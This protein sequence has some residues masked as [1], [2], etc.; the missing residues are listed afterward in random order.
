M[1]KRG[2]KITDEKGVLRDSHNKWA[3]VYL[4]EKLNIKNFKF[5][6][7]ASALLTLAALN[8]PSEILI[9]CFGYVYYS[10]DPIYFKPIIKIP[11]PK[12]ANYKV[13]EEQL[14]MLFYLMILNKE[15][16]N[17]PIFFNDEDIDYLGRDDNESYKKI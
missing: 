14:D 3:E 16:T 6:Q 13:T 9:H 8:G 5:N 4:K 7:T 1:C 10:H 15:N 2:E 17:I 12:I 11:D